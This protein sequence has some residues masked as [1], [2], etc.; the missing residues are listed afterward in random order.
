MALLNTAETLFLKRVGVEVLPLA[1]LASSGL[2]VLTTS[3]VGRIASRDPQRWLARLVGVVALAPM[4]FIFAINSDSPL[5]FGAFVLVARQVFALGLLAFWLAMGSLVPGRR[6]KQLFAPLASGITLGSIVGSFGSGP[7]AGL[8]GVDGLIGLSGLLLGGSAFTAIHLRRVGTRQ[9]E[10]GRGRARALQTTIDTSFLELVRTDRLFRLMGIALLCSG[11]LSPVLYYEFTSVLDAATQG[12]DGEQLLLSLYSQFRGWLNVAT[13]GSQLALSALLYRRLGLPLSMALE[14]VAYV[15]GFGWLGLDFAL[16]AA[17][18]SFGAAR[19]AETAIAE[20]AARVVYNLFPDRIRAYA[21]GLLEGPVNRLGG[22]LGNGFVLSAIALGLSAWIGWIALSVAVLWLASAIVLWRA[23]PGLLLRASAEHGLAGAGSDRATLLDSTTLRNLAKSLVDPDPRICR[24]AI[25]LVVDGEPAGVIA[26]LAQTI[27]DAPESNRPMLVESLHRLVEPMPPD[28]ARNEEAAQSLARLLRA[29]PPLP[30]GERA[31]LARIYAR[32]TASG[33][34][35]ETS[36]RESHEILERILGDREAAVRLAAIAELHRRGTPPPG[37][38]DLDRTLSDALSARD[39]LIRR[40]ARKEIRAI[41]MGA[42]PDEAWLRWSH[43]LTRH[44]VQRADRAETAEALQE[45]GRRHGKH[46][47]PAA[48]DALRFVDDRDP[49][50]R[51]AL[52]CLAGHAGLAAEAPRLVS[53]LGSSAPEEARGS[54]EGLVA[55]GPDA[56]LPL[57]IGQELGSVATREAVV[58]V[59]REL[60]VDRAMLDLLHAKEL[61]TI[62]EALVLRAAIDAIPGAVA[63]LLKRRLDERVSEGLGALLDLLSARHDEPRLAELERQLR[64]SSG[65]RERDI[66]IEA[67]ESL[68]SRAEHKAIVPIL[69][70]ED[71]ERRGRIACQALGR[72]LP[73]RARALIELSQNS[74]PTIR[75]IAQPISLEPTH[76]I[77]DAEAMPSAMKIAAQLQSAPVFGRLNTQ[78]LLALASLLQEQKISKGERIYSIGDEG[79][80]LYFLQEGE[81]EL[82]RGDLILDELSPLD[83]VPRAEDAIARSNGLLLRLDRDELIPL[84]EEAPSVTIGL[85]QLLSARVRR[86]Q[87]RFEQAVSP[88][89]NLPPSPELEDSP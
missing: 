48:E 12:P 2:L 41:L 72:D 43:L 78:Q 26:L 32:L 88:I 40:A 85:A 23:Y 3:A 50:V 34:T 47:Q 77:S 74:D 1:L 75:L 56:A 62:H 65:G 16:V 64:R 86:L 69:E 10:P 49:R 5:V 58:S 82:R 14:P 76:E 68:L 15:I 59:L 66:L 55:L 70:S 31:D 60:E 42:N 81:V 30:T 54:R 36:A 19:L 57:L 22:M 45:V 28:S 73:D 53:A 17:F 7:I 6:A 83:G 20:S 79:L 39:A 46:I 18:S 89:T 52:L 51:G 87:D 24:A 35:S 71:C 63:S 33:E 21:S 27:E 44:L 11:A 67:I 4:P 61:E 38:P 13:L 84:L 80:G 37:L 9:L 29:R 25:D 8:I